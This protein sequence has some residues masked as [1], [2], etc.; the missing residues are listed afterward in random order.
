MRFYMIDIQ[1]A[2]ETRASLERKYND[3]Y[4][5]LMTFILQ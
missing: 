4:L 3:I 5:V 2:S 1:L